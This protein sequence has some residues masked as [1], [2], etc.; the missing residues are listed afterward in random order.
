[1]RLKKVMLNIR[2][3]KED[4]GSIWWQGVAVPRKHSPAIKDEIKPGSD[5]ELPRRL[6]I[7]GVALA[8]A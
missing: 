5:R 4:H 1:V 7:P 8:R 2:K 3:V 6:L